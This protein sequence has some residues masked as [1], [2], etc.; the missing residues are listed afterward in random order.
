MTWKQKTVIKILM[1][2]ADHQRGRMARRRNQ[3]PQQSHQRRGLEQ[4][5]MTPQTAQFIILNFC[6]VLASFGLNG[7]PEKLWIRLV[8]STVFLYAGLMLGGM[9]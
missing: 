8:A 2:G 6:I 4:G 3:E 5:G 1:L 7:R 9:R